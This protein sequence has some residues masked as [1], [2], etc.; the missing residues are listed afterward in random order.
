VTPN[1][2][3]GRAFARQLDD[4]RDPRDNDA[5]QVDPDPSTYGEVQGQITR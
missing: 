4:S 3:V 1:R 2:A 5:A